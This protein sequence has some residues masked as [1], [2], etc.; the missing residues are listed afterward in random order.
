MSSPIHNIVAD[1]KCGDVLAQHTKEVPEEEVKANLKEE[2]CNICLNGLT[3]ASSFSETSDFTVSRLSKCGHTFHQACLRGML[4]QAGDATYQ[5]LRCPFCQKDHGVRTGDCPSGEMTYGL[6][7]NR[8]ETGYPDANGLIWIRYDIPRG[9]QGP[10][11]PHPGKKYWTN[12]FPRYGYIPNNE[13]GMLVLQLH[14]LAWERRLT[15]TV[16]TS[17][18]TGEDNQVIWNEIHHKTLSPGHSFPDPDYIDR[19]VA[20]LAAHGVSAD[21]LPPP[22]DGTSSSSSPP[23]SP[24]RS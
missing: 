17:M 3:E 24:K 9:K 11:H 22:E 23:K 7:D 5:Y 1:P 16:G 14:I 19:V 21:D 12:G 10:E 20:E 2:S 18:T 8:M 15:F 6:D 4:R 13:R